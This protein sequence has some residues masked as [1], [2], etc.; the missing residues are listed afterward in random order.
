M[1][2]VM[3]ATPAYEQHLRGEIERLERAIAARGTG[4][5]PRSRHARSYLKQ[6]RRDREDDLKR[7][8]ARIRDA[9]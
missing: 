2:A 7:L 4:T 5:D 8:H 3:W 9:T 1:N 6:L